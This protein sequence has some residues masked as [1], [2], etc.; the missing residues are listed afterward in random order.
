MTLVATV[1]HGPSRHLPPIPAARRARLRPL[2]ARPAFVGA[3]RGPLAAPTQ[4]IAGHP[5]H[6]P[7]GAV[8]RGEVCALRRVQAKVRRVVVDAVV[9]DVVDDLGA[10]QEAAVR[11]LPG[12]SVGHDP[13]A[14]RR[15]RVGRDVRLLVSAPAKRADAGC[16][17]LGG[18]AAANAPAVLSADLSE[19]LFTDGLSG[20][21]GPALDGRR[22]AG[23]RERIHA[24]RIAQ[25]SKQKREWLT[26]SV[27]PAWRPV[28]QRSLFPV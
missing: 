22:A 12:E 9:V 27:P 15:V 11:L 20:A 19:A 25:R 23:A 24:G 7:V 10:G 4:G 21:V 3:V 5:G 6:H 13:P 18:L 17:G 28:V 8:L 2:P 16:A 1:A 14:L 26:C